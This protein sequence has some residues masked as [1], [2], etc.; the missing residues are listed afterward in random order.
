MNT[1]ANGRACVAYTANGGGRLPPL[2]KPA[3]LSR[4]NGAHIC[5]AC[6]VRN[7]LRDIERRNAELDGREPMGA[8]DAL[9]FVRPGEQPH[10]VVRV[11]G[12]ST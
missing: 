3:V 8:I 5:A 11:T 4:Y 12:V 1:C 7:V 2:L 10:A 6:S 9:Q